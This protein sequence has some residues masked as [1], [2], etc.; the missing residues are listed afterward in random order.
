MEESYRMVSKQYHCYVCEKKLKKMISVA[1]LNNKNI[2]C[3]ICNQDF[4]ELIENN[5][6]PV[7]EQI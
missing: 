5:S 6:E 3:D 4:V 7:D 1:D 2:R